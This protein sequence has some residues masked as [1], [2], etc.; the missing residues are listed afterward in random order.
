M[1]GTCS[2]HGE[3]KTAYQILLK[4]PEEER[5][6]YRL[7]VDIETDM[8]GIGCEELKSIESR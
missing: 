1:G 2:T 3:I 4:I 6:R 8:K 7:E 5:P